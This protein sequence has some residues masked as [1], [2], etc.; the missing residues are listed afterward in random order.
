LLVSLEV[1]AIGYLGVFLSQVAVL[2]MAG[3][4]WS[5]VMLVA[6]LATV[7]IGFRR[8]GKRALWLLLEAPVILLPFYG[9]FFV[10]L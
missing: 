5:L 1:C 3:M 6:W 2:S 9:V 8:Y 7:I 4:A 10:D